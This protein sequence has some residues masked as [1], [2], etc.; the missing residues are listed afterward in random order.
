MRLR[1]RAYFGGSGGFVF[2][3]TLASVSNY[4]VRAQAVYAG[5]DQTQPAIV[6]IVV[7]AGVKISATQGSIGALQF[8]G[9]WPAGSSFALVIQ[10]GAKIVG[11]GGYGGDGQG[12]TGWPVP[13]PGGPGGTAVLTT[14]PLTIDNQGT[15]AGGG[16]GGGG[17][18]S[19]YTYGTGGNPDAFAGGGG[20]GGGAG[21]DGGLAGFNGS[22]NL[23]AAPTAGTENYGGGGGGSY[24]SNPVGGAVATSG[25]GGP[26]GG[27]GQPGASGGNTAN[28]YGAAGG[29]AGAYVS[30][31]ALV[32]WINTGTRLGRAV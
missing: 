16:G 21:I 30:G 28:N 24:T 6:R 26:G 9:A 17:G 1:R 13:G 7:P 2:E 18:G 22:Q 15:I 12:A 32:T 25:A 3:R 20:G 14:V 11:G 23:S 31:A 4:D 8:N 19:A 29:P 5:W 27:P 10:A